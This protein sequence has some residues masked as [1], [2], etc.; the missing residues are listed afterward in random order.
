MMIYNIYTYFPVY[1]W[2]LPY[3]FITV[4]QRMETAKAGVNYV[5]LTIYEITYNCVIGLLK[6]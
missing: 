5:F 1:V 2:N 4:K 6:S 3:T